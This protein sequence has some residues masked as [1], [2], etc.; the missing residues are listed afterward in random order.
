MK[1]NPP[2]IR[3][4]LLN[5]VTASISLALAVLFVT[6]CV[7]INRLREAQDSFNQAAAAENAARVDA[8]PANTVA[9]LA[10]VPAGY[11]SALLSLGKLE[12]KDQQSLQQDGLWGTTLTLKALCQ[13]RLGQYA[14]ALASSADA[15]KNFTKQ[16]YPRD[17][18]LLTALPGLIKTDQAYAKTYSY[19]PSLDPALDKA[20][21]EEIISLLTG[22]NGA[23]VDLKNARAAV[24]TNHPVQG[25]LIQAQLA[26]YRNY[27]VANDRLNHHAPA[28]N[29]LSRSNA[30]TQLS[31]LNNLLKTEKP[32]PS[33]RQ[34]VV[35]WAEVC[36][37]LS[38]PP[39]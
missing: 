1:A 6:G 34:L 27:T 32:G 33:G 28:P 9:S 21:L 2:F 18:A 7:S 23:V 39:P 29:D 5:R 24:D 26:A 25:Y 35:Y 10:S 17:Q 30:V 8:D 12:S 38:P 19:S 37:N 14:E 20:H 22:P 4:V 11:A 31:D 16:L 15:Q 36:G 13:W 3:R